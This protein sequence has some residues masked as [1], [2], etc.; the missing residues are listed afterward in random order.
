MAQH[1]KLTPRQRQVFDFV[2]T[3]AEEIGS[4]PTLEEICSHFSFKSINSARQHLNLIARKGYLKLLPGRARGI[5][6]NHDIIPPQ[7]VVLV[8]LVGRIA[9]GDPI[10]AIEHVEATIQVPIELWR[11]DKLFASRVHGDSMMGAGIF[12]GDIAIVN[13]QPMAANGDIA[14]VVIGEDITLKRFFR[15]V[16][17]V[18]LRAENSTYPDLF[19]A[20]A[21]AD[22]IRIAGVLVGT[23]RK[24]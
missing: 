15:S 20:R 14:A 16:E 1:R 9:A 23:I 11:G 10:V 21:D 2:R 24:F 17:G 18:R 12:D 6:L 4:A 5:R 19:F 7:S 8:P 3:Y 22:A 13:A